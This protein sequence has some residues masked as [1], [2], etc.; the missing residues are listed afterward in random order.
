MATG[1]AGAGFGMLGGAS[2]AVAATA[3]VVGGLYVAGVIGP[4]QDPAPAEVQS[5]P[6][7]QDITPEPAPVEV[8]ELPSSETA[9]PAETAV[10]EAADAPEVE[11]SA[12]P[13]AVAAPEPP[14][15]APEPVS[16]SEPEPEPAPT[17][18]VAAAP[19]PEAV[20]PEPETGSVAEPQPEVAQVPA[21]AGNAPTPTPSQPAA[22]EQAEAA[23][24][25]DTPEPAP[26]PAPTEHLAALAPETTQPEPT[27]Q[28]APEQAEPEPA[29]TEAPEIAPALDQPSFDIV[30]VEADGMTVIAGT[31]AVGSKVT[32]FL[33]DVAQQ[34]ETVDGSGKFV[35][36]LFLPLSADLRVLTM[37]ADRNGAQAW[38]G[39]Q[40]ILAPSPIPEP[41]PETVVV[42]EAAPEPEPEPSAAPVPAD[43]VV[44]AKPEPSA[45]AEPEPEAEPEATPSEPVQSAET[46]EPAP[47]EAPVV[48][49]TTAT[50]AAPAA[51]PAPEPE[52]EQVA[53]VDPPQPPATPEPLIEAAPQTSSAEPAQPSAPATPVTV[54]RA[55]A[56][57]VEVL[58]TATAAAPDVMDQ[59]ALDTISYSELGE[60]QLSGRARVQSVIRIYLDNNA[61]SELIADDEGRWRTVL[62]GIDPGIY[63]LRL[64]EVDALGKVTSRIETPFKRE[65]PAALLTATADQPP[66]APFTGAVTVQKGDTLWAISRER[67]GEG[68]LYVRVFA[69]NRDRIRNP[70]LIYPGQ[71]FTIPN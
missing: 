36:F 44:K 31:G 66:D 64:D 35:S 33:D 70:D 17:P 5:A 47:A 14:T 41:E 10:T 6:V 27:P 46:P 63:T 1:S 28:A 37:R 60:V 13:E 19:E 26:E 22:S 38:S 21:P 8:A 49:T 9:T 32:I 40:I 45:V 71:I 23:I 16:R 52:P 24:V 42:A 57:G 48:E 67:Y 20:T 29:V 43:P 15:A 34:T 11:D 56:D 12:E 2:V 7:Q 39:D 30:R 65:A 4:A 18:E 69:A 25:A 62:D 61:I 68:V 54:L 58:Q 53:V 51:D 55:T 3:V 59:I 50:A